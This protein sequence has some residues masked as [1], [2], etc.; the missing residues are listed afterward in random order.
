MTNIPPQ[1]SLSQFFEENTPVLV[2]VRFPRMGTSPD[3]YL[4]DAESEFDAIWERLGIG[5]EVHLHSAWE[6]KDSS[7]PVVLSR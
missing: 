2:E 7:R 4:C 1:E 6:M 3:W 5:A